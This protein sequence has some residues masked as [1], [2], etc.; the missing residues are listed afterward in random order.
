MMGRLQSV[1]GQQTILDL[2]L[3]GSH[4]SLTYDLSTTVS[5]GGYDDS[6]DLSKFLHG[7]SQFGLVPSRWIRKQAKTQILDITGQ[8]N[9]GIRF[10]DFRTMY[11]S[12]LFTHKD[13]YSLHFVQSKRKALEYFKEIRVWLDAHPSE[14]VVIWISRHGSQCTFGNDQYPGVSISEK[15]KYWKAIQSVFSGLLLDTVQ[16]PLNET[17][18]TTLIQ[19]NQRVIV[20]ASDYEQLTGKSQYAMDACKI[21][22]RDPP[23]VDEEKSTYQ[24][25]MKILSNSKTILKE[26]KAQN[27]FFLMSLASSGARQYLK[28]SFLYS[29]FPLFKTNRKSCA[30][31]FK[32]PG[33]TDWCPLTLLDMNR[34]ANYYNQFTLDL[35][36]TCDLDFPNAI[37]LDGLYEDG[38]ILTGLASGSKNISK[39]TK[40]AYADSLLLMNV[41]RGCQ[42]SSH[43]ECESLLSMLAQRRAMYPAQLLNDPSH[44]RLDNWPVENAGCPNLIFSND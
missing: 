31:T 8:L 23:S 28:Y 18:L 27:R 24:E 4:D 17:S 37:Y 39:D 5:D 33:M 44:G 19:R 3:P 43:P 6:N 11:T 10:I 30:A 7:A 2:S 14:V 41:R 20:Y 40:F 25:T 36:V 21:D 32:I 26:D 15:Q 13:W 9:N 29:H 42:K 34:L 12:T 38:T 16:S 35:A 1:I 22:D